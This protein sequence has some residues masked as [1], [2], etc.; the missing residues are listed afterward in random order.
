MTISSKAVIYWSVGDNIVIAILLKFT[1]IMLE[2]EHLNIDDRA[3][4]DTTIQPC[5]SL[6]RWHFMDYLVC[7]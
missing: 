2:T 4:Q 5:T 1:V 6:G 3:T 7:I